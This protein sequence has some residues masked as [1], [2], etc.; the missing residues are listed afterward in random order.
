VGHE[1]LFT[2]DRRGEDWSWGDLVW[3]YGAEVSA[4]SFHDNCAELEVAPGERVGE[5]AAVEAIPRSAHYRV[6]S[7]VTTS[8]AG[9]EEDLKLERD[10]G[11]NVIRL[12]GT[13]P[14]EG[15]PWK[16]AVALEDPA[17]YAATAFADILEA[18]GIRVTG[19]AATS[20]EPLPPV[21]LRV[22]AETES[23]TMAALVKGVN[24][25]SQNLWTEML[26][27]LLGA[28]VKGVGSVEAGHEAAGEFLERLGVVSS[29]WAFQDGSGLSRSDLLP[30]RDL[31]ALLVAMDRHPHAAAFRE[32]LPIAGADGTLKNR[33]KGTSAEGR[34]VAKTGSLRHVS[35][36]AGY[37]HRRD[38]SRLAF[39]IAVNHFTVPSDEARAAI[40]EIC[41][42][43]VE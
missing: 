6:V 15:A 37:A 8:A 16:G 7:T 5:P 30:P 38:G 13:L 17:R 2:G 10:F 19:G 42:A 21:G 12:S 31:A 28:R 14:L 29:A 41:R 11:T 27:R 34:I 20:S 24:K 33:M 22:L 39:A 40:D 32:S 43:L 23:P 26:L 3:C 25:P 35:A 4:L 1:G 9:T 18:K 36:L